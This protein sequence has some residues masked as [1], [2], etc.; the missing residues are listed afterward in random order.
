[1]GAGLCIGIGGVRIGRAVAWQILEAVSERAVEAAIF[2]SDQVERSTKEFVAAVERDLEGAAMMY[3]SPRVNT[4]SW[5]PPSATS[6][7]SLRRVGTRRWST[8][9][10]LS[11][12]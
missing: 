7:A 2:A 10:D 5:I 1:M 9:R 8:W 4:N 3:L 12:E 6:P 11:A